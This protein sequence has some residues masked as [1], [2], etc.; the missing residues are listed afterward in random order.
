SLVTSGHLKIADFL[1]GH[2]QKVEYVREH[3]PL[4]FIEGHFKLTAHRRR[5]TIEAGM[6]RK[7][8]KNDLRF[9]APD[10]E[11]LAVSTHELF[12]RLRTAPAAFRQ[13][14]GHATLHSALRPEP[15]RLYPPRHPC[16]QRQPRV[17]PQGSA[18]WPAV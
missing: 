8:G 10:L 16:G 4:A 7:I 13:A 1:I 12:R 9:L 17:W 6:L 5:E 18:T 15:A 11:H 2:P 14:G 3:R